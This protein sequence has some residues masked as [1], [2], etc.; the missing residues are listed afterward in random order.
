MEPFDLAIIFT[1][2]GALIGAALVTAA[3]ELLK[4][5]GILAVHGRAPMLAAAALSAGL[6]LLGAWSIGFVLSPENL[7][8]GILAWINVTT[9][10][11]GTHATVRKAGAIASGSTNPGGPDPEG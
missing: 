5:L 8:L 9:A 3:V 1:A 4:R 6:V 11:I 7:L 10:A 2:A